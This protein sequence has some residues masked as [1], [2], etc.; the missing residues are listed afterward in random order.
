MSTAGSPLPLA[1]AQLAAIRQLAFDPPSADWIATVR[2]ALILL[3]A[4]VAGH[5]AA[6]AT[7]EGDLQAAAQVLADQLHRLRTLTSIREFTIEPN[8]MVPSAT[9]TRVRNGLAHA[10]GERIALA[11]TDVATALAAVLAALDARYHP[12]PGLNLRTFPGAT[13]QDFLQG[14]LMSPDLVDLIETVTSLLPH[15]ILKIV[16]EDPVPPPAPAPRRPRVPSP[17]TTPIP[18]IARLSTG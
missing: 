14:L 5:Q 16:L 7:T 3:T 1:D 2:Q 6:T 15:R 12:D 8:A 10:T 4:E 18:W 13:P 11:T 9:L 17:A